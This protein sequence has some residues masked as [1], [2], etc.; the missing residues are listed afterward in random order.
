MSRKRIANILKVKRNNKQINIKYMKKE[1]SGF[2]ILSWSELLNSS[3]RFAPL[4]AGASEKVFLFGNNIFV[5]A[6]FKNNNIYS[7]SEH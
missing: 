4:A 7:F 1:T 5:L 3:G 2:S 6:Y